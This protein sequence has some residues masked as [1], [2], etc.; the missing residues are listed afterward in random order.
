MKEWIAIEWIV[1][2]WIVKEWIVREWIAKEIV[3]VTGK[4]IDNEH[5][6]EEVAVVVESEER[7]HLL[8]PVIQWISMVNAV[9]KEEIANTTL[10]PFLLLPLLLTLCLLEIIP[11]GMIVEDINLNRVDLASCLEFVLSS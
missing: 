3:N 9:S 5:L 6:L 11:Q 4:E 2:E 1:R 7:I 8:L 10:L